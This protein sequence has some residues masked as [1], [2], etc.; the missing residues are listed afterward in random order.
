LLAPKQDVSYAE[1]PLTRAEFATVKDG[2]VVSGER[3]F[4]LPLV[5]LLKNRLSGRL[6][7]GMWRFDGLMLQKFPG[8]EHFATSRVMKL[9]KP[10]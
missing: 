5:P 9:E 8:L 10:A 6:F 1:H 4:R 2:W 3:A 7:D